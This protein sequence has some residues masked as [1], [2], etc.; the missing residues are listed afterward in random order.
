MQYGDSLRWYSITCNDRMY[1]VPADDTY[2]WFIIIKFLSSDLTISCLRLY[3]FDISARKNVVNDVQYRLKQWVF[4]FVNELVASSSLKRISHTRK[5]VD[6]AYLWS[7]CGGGSVGVVVAVVVVVVV[8]VVV[9]VV[10]I[11]IVVVV[12]LNFL[13]W[14]HYYLYR[15][16]LQ[17][18]ICT[19]LT[20]L[21][22]AQHRENSLVH[23]S[24][25]MSL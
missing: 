2:A 16:E 20:M 24:Q 13:I 25:Q 8:V 6:S 12:V 14:F 15:L 9:F 4:V 10:V 3:V 23:S 19:Q 7:G 11:V 21:Q 17:Q 18:R 1:N 22:G 5:I